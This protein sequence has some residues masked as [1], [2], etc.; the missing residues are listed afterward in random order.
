VLRGNKSVTELMVLILKIKKMVKSISSNTK[1]IHD[2]QL[3]F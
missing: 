2:K 1:V 3:T